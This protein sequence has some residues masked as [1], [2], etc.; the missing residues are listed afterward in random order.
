MPREK[1]KVQQHDQ[2]RHRGKRSQHQVHLQLADVVD[3]ES[4]DERPEKIGGG[5]SHGDEG[6]VASA[7]FGAVDSADD[8]LQ[9]DAE[10]LVR[11]PEFIRYRN[12]AYDEKDTEVLEYF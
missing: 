5:P 11:Q 10:N 2:Y 3:R 12:W 6:I 9:R 8:S 1:P 7:V 4:G